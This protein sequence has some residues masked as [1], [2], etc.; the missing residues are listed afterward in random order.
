MQGAVIEDNIRSR[1]VAVDFA[2][3][4]VLVTSLDEA[5]THDNATV[6][7]DNDLVLA[8]TTVC[9]LNFC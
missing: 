4:N 6:A 3:Q 8:V 5:C 2:R 9:H 1:S 7:I